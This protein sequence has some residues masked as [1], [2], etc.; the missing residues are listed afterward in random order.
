[1]IQRF[2][3][4]AAVVFTLLC[5]PPSLSAQDDTGPFAQAPFAQASKRQGG[6]HDL[7]T[8]ADKAKRA[9]L[10]PRAERE[11]AMAQVREVFGHPDD[12]KRRAALVKGLI[13]AGR[14]DEEP[15]NRYAALRRAGELAV[16]GADLAAASE[17][18][19]VFSEIFDVDALAIKA[20]LFERLFGKVS[21]SLAKV[22]WTFEAEGAK[23]VGQRRLRHRSESALAG[24][25]RESCAQ[26]DLHEQRPGKRERLSET[27][28]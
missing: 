2:F 24:E 28:L 16:E 9:P 21:A 7:L 12:P 26:C 15:V 14:E 4:V 17:A 1:M 23:E 19:D 8:P 25:T 13:K 5:H 18:A 10:P 11:K 27:S 6:L 20:S 3:M 22:G